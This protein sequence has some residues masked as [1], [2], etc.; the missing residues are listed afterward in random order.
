MSNFT[1][2][3]AAVLKAICHNDAQ[4]GHALRLLLATAK[5]TKRDNTGLGFYT[6]FDIQ[7]DPKPAILDPRY[8]VASAYME[9]M[10]KSMFMGFNLW[11]EDG[12]PDCLEGF[13]YSDD[14]GNTVDLTSYDLARLN[15]TRLDPPLPPST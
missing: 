7:L 5:V 10:G 4:D 9:A 15:I 14:Q 11:F 2:L 12:Y 6:F 1:V 3:E 13:Q 8:R